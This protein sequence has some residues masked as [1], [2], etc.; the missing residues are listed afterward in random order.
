M[1]AGCAQT[2]CLLSEQLQHTPDRLLPITLQ[3]PR[4]TGYPSYHL[5][6]SIIQRFKCQTEHSWHKCEH[7]AGFSSAQS[8]RALEAA[9][10][11]VAALIGAARPSEVVF[12]ACGT[13]SNNW[14]LAGAALAWREGRPGATPHVVASAVEHP[15]VTEC[16]KALAGLVRSCSQTACGRLQKLR[17]AFACQPGALGEAPGW[18]GGLLGH[19]NPMCLMRVLYVLMRQW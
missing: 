17:L 18:P 10:E 12:T 13:E 7:P 3:A 8:K 2:A 16:L 1:G 9:R 5:L 6:P 4:R 14:A 15:A 11:A 19:R